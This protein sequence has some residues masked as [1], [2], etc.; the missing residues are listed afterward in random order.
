[1]T[2]LIIIVTQKI[3]ETAINTNQL[4]KVRS[5][6][7]FSLLLCVRSAHIAEL[8]TSLLLAIRKKEP[9]NLMKI[10]DSIKKFESSQ[11][12]QSS[13]QVIDKMIFSKRI[14]ISMPHEQSASK[15]NQ[16]IRL[17]SKIEN[18]FNKCAKTG[19][20]L[21]EIFCHLASSQLNLNAFNSF[22]QRC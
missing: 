7:K 19:S 14:S 8:K 10:V 16:I 5:F 9:L 12:D 1:L 18:S 2:K 3:L 15:S 22:F 21:A 6:L 4:S 20:L 11:I 13:Y 17:Y